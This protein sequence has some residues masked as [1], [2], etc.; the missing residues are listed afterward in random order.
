[1]TG[2][3]IR[4]RYWREAGVCHRRWSASIVTGV[5]LCAVGLQVR[6]TGGL[7]V[8]VGL[9]FVMLLVERDP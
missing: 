2:Y 8:A 3:V 1:M 5:E 9:F 7:R 4:R 6:W